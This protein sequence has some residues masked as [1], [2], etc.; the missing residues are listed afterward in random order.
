[1]S[2]ITFS[3]GPYLSAITIFPFSIFGINFSME[4]AYFQK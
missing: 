4:K 2:I 1:M 3:E